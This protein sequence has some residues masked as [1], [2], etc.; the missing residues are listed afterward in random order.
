MYSGLISQPI[1]FRPNFFAAIAVVPIPTKQSNTK[2]PGLL[3][4]LIILSIKSRGLGVTWGNLG[5]LPFI[6]FLCLSLEKCQTSVQSL[7]FGLGNHLLPFL[8][9]PFFLACSILSTD[10]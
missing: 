1:K 3:L 2:S 10:S 5:V 9:I 7:P 6:L 8:I 4:A